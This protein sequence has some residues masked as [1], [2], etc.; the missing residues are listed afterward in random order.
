MKPTASIE[1]GNASIWHF[2]GAGGAF[3][4]AA[5]GELVGQA[6]RGSAGAG[7][8]GWLLLLASGAWVVGLVWRERVG[9]F[10]SWLCF[11]WVILASL[12]AMLLAGRFGFLFGHMDFTGRES[13]SLGRVPVSLLLLWWVM[14]GGGYLVVEGL[15]GE[16]RAGVSALTALVAVQL[17]LM[18][19]PF[20]VRLRDYW[21]WSAGSANSSSTGGAYFGAPWIVLAGWFSLALGLALGLVILGDNWSSAEA[22]TRRQAW[23]PAA[24]LL[25]LTVV[26]LGAEISAG[27]WLPVAFGAANAVLFGT[28]VVWYFRERAVKT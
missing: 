13:V 19:L 22:R 4:A 5:G 26:C 15:W 17:A 11:V 20:A 9:I 21:R 24:V 7:Q 28:V 8:T 23:T 16:W 27:L 6:M 2:R 14:A 3:A 18:I 25:T 12:L 10:R 1:V